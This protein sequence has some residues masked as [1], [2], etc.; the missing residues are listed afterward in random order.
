MGEPPA[1]VC[2]WLLTGSL[3]RLRLM[4]VCLALE[5]AEAGLLP[6]CMDE[7]NAGVYE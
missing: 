7:P 5:S 6:E 2:G 3:D 4:E 1:K